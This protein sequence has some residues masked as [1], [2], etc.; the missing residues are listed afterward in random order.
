MKRLLPIIALIATPVFAGDLTT[1]VGLYQNG[2]RVVVFTTVYSG[3]SDAE[4]VAMKARATKV[5]DEASKCQNKGGDYSSTWAWGT[6]P[7]IE[8]T[9]MTF[10]C[11]NKVTRAAIKFA[12]DS[13]T[14][15]EGH[16]GK[17]H[18]RPWGN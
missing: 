9:G 14:E 4:Q 6:D 13:A 17:G 15:A 16:A 8:T 2:A 3:M 7:A 10:Q 11:A 1:S 12:T 18:K 5:L